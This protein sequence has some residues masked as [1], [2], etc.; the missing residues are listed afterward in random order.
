MTTSP[1]AL[2]HKFA[3]GP[4]GI[5]SGLRLLMWLQA[6]N[7]FSIP[8]FF[9]IVAVL[10]LVEMS[11]LV[12]IGVNA[13]LF[14]PTL[15]ASWA[16]VRVVDGEGLSS[17]GL[18][19]SFARAFGSFWIGTTIGVG[20]IAT[21]LVG[22]WGTGFA[23]ISFK[24]GAPLSFSIWLGALLAAATL[25]E[26][27][28]RGYAFQWLVRGLGKPGA[29]ALFA[30]SFAALHL[31][32]PNIGALG[33]TSIAAAS[34]LL[35]VALFRSHDLWLPSGL[36]WGWNLAQGILFGVPISGLSSDEVPTLFSTTFTGPDWLTGGEFGFEGSV[37]AI[38]AMA[39]G[40][41]ALV[42]LPL[43]RGG[44]DFE[45]RSTPSSDET[46]PADTEP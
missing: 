12:M 22:L 33:F 24:G 11:T 45:A 7:V 34:V 27:L 4:F 35:S 26:L 15:A 44:V 29:T 6:L 42:L 36:H 19:G 43:P 38:A 2:A 9:V 1:R 16:M 21:I 41:L 17:M 40:G 30:L 10:G 39:L 23:E 46:T 25:E 32:N 20:M 5:R 31:F 18:G 14:L 28:F 3:Y 13:T 8:L 37:L